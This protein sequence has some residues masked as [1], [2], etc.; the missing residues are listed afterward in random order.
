[1]NFCD[2]LRLYVIFAVPT[3]THVSCTSS[4]S[5][6]YRW[7]LVVRRYAPYHHILSF[8]TNP[9][10]STLKSLNVLS[11]FVS[12]AART[13]LPVTPADICAESM[14]RASIESFS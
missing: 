12:T 13:L 8:V 14:L 1:M 11:R 5:V 6:G 9:P 3:G 10:R 4:T 7:P 2:E